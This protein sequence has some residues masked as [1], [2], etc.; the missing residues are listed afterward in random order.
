MS[1]FLEYFHCVQAKQCS[2]F[3]CN[4][5]QATESASLPNL[6]PKLYSEFMSS[7]SSLLHHFIQAGLL[8]SLDLCKAEVKWGGYVAFISQMAESV[9]GSQQVPWYFTV[10]GQF[11]LP[12][13]ALL[14][15]HSSHC[16]QFTL[17]CKVML[18]EKGMCHPETCE[19]YHSG[20]PRWIPAVSLVG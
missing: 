19:S 8:P 6:W 16:P 14:L 15:P 18:K 10:Q 1:L 4:G 11:L 20:Q 17:S 5:L 3:A 13:L 9:C 7:R 12:G 2:Q